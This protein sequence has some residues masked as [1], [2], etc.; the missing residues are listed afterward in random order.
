M[1][2]AVFG[3]LARSL[4][5]DQC[6]GSAIL[7]STSC[8]V[9]GDHFARLCEDRLLWCRHRSVAWRGCRAKLHL[10]L[11]ADV[12]AWIVGTAVSRFRG[13]KRSLRVAKV[14]PDLDSFVVAL[15]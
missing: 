5:L 14:T 7:A 12:L 10:R 2:H 3:E 4:D 15:R 13:F 9:V 8:S 1:A 6:L 11:L